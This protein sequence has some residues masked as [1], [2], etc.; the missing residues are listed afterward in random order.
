MALPSL[1]LAIKLFLLY[2]NLWLLPSVLG[3]SLKSLDDCHRL[4]LKVSKA[5]LKKKEKTLENK[6]ACMTGHFW[7][8]GEK[9]EVES[10]VCVRRLDCRPLLVAG[11][12]TVHCA[13]CFSPLCTVH[14]APHRAAAAPPVHTSNR[15]RP[16][17]HRFLQDDLPAR[18]L[19]KAINRLIR[20]GFIQQ[21]F[22]SHDLQEGELPFILSQI[23]QQI[24]QN[25]KRQNWLKWAKIQEKIHS[26]HFFKKRLGLS[27]WHNQRRS[28]TN[29][30][31]SNLPVSV[32]CCNKRCLRPKRGPPV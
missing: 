26:F 19:E 23:G 24:A 22:C 17:F 32:Q 20:R 9:E 18:W 31:K 8:E 27:S 4:Q 1:D 3:F 7:K 30:I 25:W 10:T 15:S 14:C 6:T 5:T 2:T 28:Y 11:L 13:L 29:Q 21:R 12:P 16:V